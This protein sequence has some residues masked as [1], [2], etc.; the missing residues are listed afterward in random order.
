MGT[1]YPTCAYLGMRKVNEIGTWPSKVNRDWEVDMDASWNKFIDNATLR[2]AL[3]AG[4]FVL[5][6]WLSF[7]LLSIH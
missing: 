3:N 6:F 7:G 1:L 5:W 4:V 2:S